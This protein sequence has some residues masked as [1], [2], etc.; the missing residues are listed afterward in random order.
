[1]ADIYIKIRPPGGD[2]V[3]ISIDPGKSVLELKRAI[4]QKNGVPPEEQRLIFKGQVLQDDKPLATYQPT[5]GVVFHLV[6]GRRSDSSSSSPDASQQQPSV[7]SA[8]A[9]AAGAAPEGQGAEA[10][11]GLLPAGLQAM[12]ESLTRLVGGT[13]ADGQT[14]GMIMMNTTTGSLPAPGN[15]PTAVVRITTLPQ[16]LQQSTQ[17]TPAATNAPDHL[18]TV[19]RALS[20]HGIASQDRGGSL[21]F[22]V[23]GRTCRCVCTSGVVFMEAYIAFVDPRHA[24]EVT[25]VLNAEQ[26][27]SLLG[28][29]DLAADGTV[30]L[31]VTFFPDTHTLPDTAVRRFLAITDG[32]A[33]DLPSKLSRFL[34]RDPNET[35]PY[36]LGVRNA[37]VH[38]FDVSEAACHRHGAF[39]HGDRVRD[40]NGRT[41]TTIGVRKD[42]SGQE[43]L[44]F[45]V[46][47]NSGAGVYDAA[48]ITT[49][50]RVGQQ[51][52]HP[53]F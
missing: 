27:A 18:G 33:R 39:S 37:T 1:M 25:V 36:M 48:A 22:E 11:S 49:L 23:L 6:I 53:A 14:A 45:H 35:F 21:F 31:T 51:T 13:A 26:R 41:A 32:I 29:L 44:W 8:A 50:Q 2:T 20:A 28:R 10:P 15:A 46:D 42:R 4:A 38:W 34:P 7:S 12:L 40:A 30:T 16:L 43:H 3:L 47:G 17:G 19:R 5:D 52:V 24:S 9:A